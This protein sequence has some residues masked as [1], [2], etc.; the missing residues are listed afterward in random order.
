VSGK[1]WLAVGVMA[2][3]VAAGAWFAIH[4]ITD[5]PE[6]QPLDPNPSS[7]FKLV[8]MGDSYISGE[9]ARH[10]FPGTDEPDGQRN[11]CHRAA[12][13]YPYL[14]AKQLDASLTFLACSGAVTQDVTGVDAAGQKV[15]GQYPRS[16]DAIGANPQVEELLKVASPSVVLISIGGNDSGFAEIGVDCA[17]PLH[18]DCR[19]LASQWLHRLDTKVYPALVRTYSLVREDA[20]GAPVFA[21][22]YPNPVGPKFCDDLL[23][24]NAAEMAFLREVFVGRLNEIVTAAAAAAGVRT[25]D[26]TNALAGYRFCEKP[27]GQT[28]INFIDVHRTSGVPIDVT[29]LGGIFHGSLHPNPLGH[30]LIDKVV[31][32]RV[33]A[34]RDGTLPP[35]PTPHPDAPPPPF[36]PSEI[37]SPDLARPFPE[38]TQCRGSELAAISQLAAE[39]SQE[40]VSLAEL[41]PNSTVCF[42]TYRAEWEAKPVGADGAVRVPID[43]S[44]AGVGSINEILVQD[45]TGAWKEIVVSR[46]SSAEG[47][48]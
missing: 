45:A 19:G 28:A 5:S 4:E 35:A 41:K 25:I 11:M 39:P 44:S 26:L 3:L 1:G 13:A 29:K 33:E 10:Y 8:A 15:P 18:S 9:G 14:L 32:P 24:L 16:G 36:V 46:L 21:L 31:L 12:T 42:R 23:G 2:V 27:L 20:H 38:G 6:S 43:V 40:Q 37:G 34:V 17:S 47:G 22:T 7:T 30:E 48:F